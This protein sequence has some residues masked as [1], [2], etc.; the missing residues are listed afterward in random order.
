MEIYYM[1]LEL[2]KVLF[3]L[4]GYENSS[5]WKFIVFCLVY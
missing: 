2:V 5:V 3:I 4:F 1:F